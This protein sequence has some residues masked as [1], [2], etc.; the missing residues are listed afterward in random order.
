MLVFIRFDRSSAG[1]IEKSMSVRRSVR[2]EERVR[3]PIVESE[4]SRH[5]RRGSEEDDEKAND[6]HHDTGFDLW[7]EKQSRVF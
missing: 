3:R 4:D 7:E 2:A 6:V 5:P 1:A